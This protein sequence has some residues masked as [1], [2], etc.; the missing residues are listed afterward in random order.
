MRKA[1]RARVSLGVRWLAEPKCLIWL[2]D[3]VG[4]ARLLVLAMPV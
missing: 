4:I 1:S 3:F 2:T